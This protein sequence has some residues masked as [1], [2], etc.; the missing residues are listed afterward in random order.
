MYQRL[1]DLVA[2]RWGWIIAG[3]GLLA[4]G[5]HLLAPRW[6]DVTHDGDLAH[7]PASATSVRGERILE[8]AFPR[9]QFKSQAVAILESKTGE[10][11]SSDDD[12][13]LYL[14]E[15]RFDALADVL[16]I[17]DVWAP[18]GSGN[19]T[20]QA[21]SSKLRSRDGQAAVVV[22]HLDTEFMAT[23][24]IQ[25]LER[26]QQTLAGIRQDAEFPQARLSL[27]VCGSG[28][29]G[30]DILVATRESI[31]RTEL[32]TVGLVLLILLLVYRSPMLTIIPVVTIVVS[33]MVASD[34]VAWAASVAGQTEWIDF[35]IFKTTRIFVVVILFGSGTDFCLFLIARYR[36]ELSRGAER[37]VAIANAL[38]NVGEA[39]TASAITTM[40]GLGMMF[41]AQFGKFSSSGPT[42][43]V[44]LAVALAASMTLAPALLR[45]AGGLVF[46]PFGMPTL[47]PAAETSIP[48]STTPVSAQPS[49]FARFWIWLSGLVL[50]RPGWVLATSVALMA[51]FALHGTGVE[52]SYNIVNELSSDRPTVQ[53]TQMFRRHFAPGDSGPVTVVAQLEDAA[54]DQDSGK[55]KIKWLHDYLGADES[56]IPFVH[57]VRSWLSP[58]GSSA[59]RGPYASALRARAEPLYIGSTTGT[60]SDV[61]RFDLILDCDPFSSDAAAALQTLQQTL[62]A[63][64]HDP[65]RL[66]GGQ[67]S[68]DALAWQGAQFDFVGVTAGTA[69]LR[70]V[71][72]S[73]QVLIQV[74]V[75]LG[76]FAVLWVILRNVVVCGYLILSVLFSYYVTLGAVDWV[77][78]ALYGE[79]FVGLNWK[80][81]LFLFVILVAVGEDYNIYLTTRVFEEQ[82]RLGPLAGLREAMIRT[83][84]IITSC[85]VIMAGTFLTMMSG[86]LRGM[87]ELGFALGLGVLLDTFVIRTMLVPAFLALL[88][89]RQPTVPVEPDTANVPGRF[90]IPYL[91]QDSDEAARSTRA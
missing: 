78:A 71:T 8:Q 14:L 62:A 72:S 7:L 86:S 73:D 61:T 52:P 50:N 45:A 64:S 48:A 10:P 42:L 25:V 38:G 2:R 18:T 5:L 74:L 76:V 19:S 65:A 67:V 11:L 80:V 16:P 51:P 47:V 60:A 81:R 26:V 22:M 83:G 46:W 63:L 84:G 57:E 40:V 70:R 34:L 55:A 88:A 15:E 32:T 53:G 28:A 91:P 31:R 49:K 23:R 69:D 6:D 75:V 58:I 39:L 43:A 29:I 68:D 66:L 44:C 79:T 37:G 27:G 1:G 24:N 35:K 4:V 30:G 21:F 77:F 9:G 13:W 36:E 82:R 90:A 12:D 59:V 41:F 3:W 54:F 17:V 20:E 87:L 56:G 89:R 85:G 33:V